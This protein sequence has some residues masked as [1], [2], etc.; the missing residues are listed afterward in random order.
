MSEETGMSKAVLQIMHLKHRYMELCDLGYPPKAL[1]KLFVEDGI[2][3]SPAFGS[4]HGVNEIEG[5]FESISTRIVF[6]AH[7]A[8]NPIIDVADNGYEAKGRWRILM[9]FTES[10]GGKRT[11]RW[12]LGDY[13]EEYVLRDAGWL[14]RKVDFFVNF[15][16]PH[17]GT[18]AD[19]AVLRP[20]SG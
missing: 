2:W 4:F 19:V 20:M 14:F 9:P 6:A 10:D 11:A 18:W 16:V 12:I 13:S 3:T 17:E 8:L 5:F 7:L 15:N 1:S